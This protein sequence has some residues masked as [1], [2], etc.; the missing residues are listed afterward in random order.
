MS[1]TFRD[2]ILSLPIQPRRYLVDTIPHNEEPMFLDAQ[3]RVENSV[4]AL[5]W[6]EVQRILQKNEEVIDITSA[7]PK[8]CH[9]K[10]LF[11]ESLGIDPSDPSFK[12]GV[13]VM[14]DKDS[15]KW[16]PYND[17]SAL[18]IAAYTSALFVKMCLTIDNPSHFPYNWP[19]WKTAFGLSDYQVHKFINEAKQLKMDEIKAAKK[20]KM[21]AKLA[22]ANAEN[23]ARNEEAEQLKKDSRV[24]ENNQLSEPE[25]IKQMEDKA[26]DEAARINREEKEAKLKR[27]EANKN[28]KVFK[29][30]FEANSQMFEKAKELHGLGF[31][32][33]FARRLKMIEA[34]ADGKKPKLRRNKN[35]DINEN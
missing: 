14:Y 8:V 19:H 23:K 13:F 3:Q 9:I 27:H 16:T 29:E 4:W 2:L 21:A 15:G 30:F 26:A 24:T 33:G 22:K 35:I 12:V 17:A 10:Q 11:V 1:D 25:R 31:M 20:A 5:D 34:L 7:F 18:V 6:F 28:K 32:S